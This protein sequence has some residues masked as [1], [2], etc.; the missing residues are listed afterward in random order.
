MCWQIKNLPLS[1]CGL[2][3]D[4]HWKFIWCE[5]GSISEPHIFFQIPSKEKSVKSVFF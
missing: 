3:I 1:F 4:C 5:I 2:F